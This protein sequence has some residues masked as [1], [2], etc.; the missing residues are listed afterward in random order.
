MKKILLLA[1]VSFS[2]FANAQQKEKK[3]QSLMWEITGNGLSKPSY[4]YGTMHVPDK[5]AF[6]LGDAFFTAIQNVDMVALEINPETWVDDMLAY[7]PYTFLG[8]NMFYYN[9]GRGSKDDKEKERNDAIAAALRSD[10]SLINYYLY[11]SQGYTGNFE[12]RTYLDL[13]IFQTGKKLGKQVA[14]LERMDE[15]MLM[16]EEAERARNEE[17]KYKQNDYNYD[18]D[19]DYMSFG[20]ILEDAY[21]RGDLDM[22]DSLNIADGTPGY[23]EYMLYRRNQMMADRMDTIMRHKNLS[24]FAGMGAS[25]LPGEKG[26]IEMLRAK[27]YTLKPIARPAER[28]TKKKAK[29]DEK[30]IK[31]NFTTQKSFD[32]Y[33]SVD[34]PGKMY[35]LTGFGP[36]RSYFHPDM[37]NGA[38]YTVTRIKTFNRDLDQAVE[39]VMHDIDSML[40]ENIPGNIKKQKTFDEKGIKGF[41]I[42]TQISKGDI[43][44]YKIIVT[45]DE[46]FVF[47]LGGMGDFA[48]D[49]EADKFFKSVKVNTP[50]KTNWL[51][52]SSPDG[53]FSVQLPHMPL[54]YG[55]TS[56][57]GVYFNPEPF[58]AVDFNNGNIY[59]VNKSSIYSSGN[60]N[61][62]DSVLLENAI[63]EFSEKKYW[64]ELSRS[65]S[66]EGD[67]YI[68][69]ATYKVDETFK[70]QVRYQLRKGLLYILSVKYKTDNPDG[71][72][73]IRSLRFIA[74]PAV[75]YET[76]TDTLMHFTVTTTSQKTSLDKLIRKLSRFKAKD[77]PYKTLYENRTFMESP[78]ADEAVSVSYV[79]YGKYTRF[80]DSATYWNDGISNLNPDS[81]RIV[82]V[83]KMYKK[84]GFDVLD[85]EYTDTGCS[86]VTKLRK[87]LRNGITYSVECVYNRN[88]GLGEFCSKFYET[89]QPKDTVI[90][91]D[92]FGENTKL[93]V[94]DLLSTDSATRAEAREML[95]SANLKESDFKVWTAVIDTMKQEGNENYFNYK[96]RFI[97]KLWEIKTPQ[98]ITYLKNVYANAGDTT[99]FQLSALKTL[100]NIETAE[101]YKAFKELLLNETPL[102]DQY[103][104]NSLFYNL[105]DS[106]ELASTLYPELLT[107]LFTLD[108]YRERVVKVLA[109]LVDSNKVKPD[110]YKDFMPNLISEAR[111]E[112]KRQ[113]A[114]EVEKDG[115]DNSYNNYYYGDYSYDYGYAYGNYLSNLSILLMP[116]YSDKNVKAIYDKLLQSKDLN[117]RMN[118]AIRLTKANYPVVDSIWTSIAAKRANRID[119]YDELEKAK[120]L[121]KFPKEYLRQDSMTIAMVWNSIN[122]GYSS[123][124]TIVLV[125]KRY[126]EFD[127][128]KGYAYLYKYRNKNSE[129][130]RLAMAGLQ[131]ADTNAVNTSY[132]FWK[133]NDRQKVNDKV[134]LEKQFT[135]MIK[136]EML[137][138]AMG[139]SYFGDYD[140][141]DYGGYGD[142]P[143]YGEEEYYEGDY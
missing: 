5:L 118:T 116:S 83:N 29:I 55:D 66:K 67:S 20:E 12:E 138:H 36:S 54:F 7:D 106:M 77:K 58:T 102:G 85:L 59:S 30:F 114:E 37:A 21:R 110:V 39:D 115:E 133:T 10:P 112:L 96:S 57:L 113:T 120:L 28:E 126:V 4:L 45:H 95:N 11:R 35:E 70:S 26:V 136:E 33:F 78:K 16:L 23:L 69:D 124:D 109:I 82:L 6:H 61:I 48:K 40:Y 90:G 24:L 104:I 60:V 64:D 72:R 25:H 43:H 135:V 88:E 46:I 137:S 76:Y 140:W 94:N 73:F 139:Y 89:F 91:V 79:R 127:G 74:P 1:F 134:S 13:Y 51:D 14:G 92:I 122:S 119:L 84:D 62:A 143:A 98:N 103:E 142:E 18:Y 105:N 56:L 71:D 41:D 47:K 19:E 22:L 100:V 27:G 53:T 75:A 49:K 9:F 108:E 31:R 93:I 132:R 32:N 87:M 38:Y 107:K 131:P 2:L 130:W 17:Y 44:R 121:D 86:H 42:T 101:S 97:E 123:A 129:T 65:V 141:S 81:T 128:D 80:K 111:N 125:E 50:S 8:D 117:T 99:T 52:F 63:F 3:Y 34:L 68:V 15:L